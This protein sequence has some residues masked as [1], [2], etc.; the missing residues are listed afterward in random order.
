MAKF[1]DAGI[2]SISDKQEVQEVTDLNAM[3]PKMDLKLIIKIDH[4]CNFRSILASVPVFVSPLAAEGASAVHVALPVPELARPRRSQRAR[5]RPLVPGG[6]QPHPEFHSRHGAHRGPLQVQTGSSC[7]HHLSVTL[8][9]LVGV[10]APERREC[11][12]LFSPAT[13][14]RHHSF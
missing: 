1:I 13:R 12:A 3:C 11:F 4:S 14:V 10:R 5:R 9:V 2:L 8:G 6:G 7:P